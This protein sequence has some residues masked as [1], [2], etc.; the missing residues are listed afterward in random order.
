MGFSNK[1]HNPTPFQVQF[2]YHKGI[3]FTIPPFEHLDLN[4]EYVEDFVPGRPGSENVSN[5][6]DFYG[7][8][9]EDPNKSY[10]AQ[11]LVALRAAI[12]ARES[13][14][15]EVTDNIRKSFAALGTGGSPEAI[16]EQLE[17]SGMNRLSA[18]VEELRELARV[19][20]KVVAS[21]KPTSS[22][23]SYDLTRTV[24][25]LDPPKQFPTAETM[26]FFLER[27][28][29]IKAKNDEM[30]NAMRVKK[31]PG[32]PPATQVTDGQ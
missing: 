6:L 12:K 17:M 14:V 30:L 32:R 15:R 21:Q 20:E 26:N 1:L 9:L 31:G 23:K 7:V 16:D 25:A 2:N 8:F 4:M 18:E 19:Y 11:A 22:V 13:M 3:N 24:I 27:N 10:E 29:D 28:P 5:E